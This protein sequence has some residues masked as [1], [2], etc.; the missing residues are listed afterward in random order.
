MLLRREMDRVVDGKGPQI[1]KTYDSE[2]TFY[3]TDARVCVLCLTAG[4][5]YCNFCN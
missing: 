5:F 2:L 3:D 1:T 4:T